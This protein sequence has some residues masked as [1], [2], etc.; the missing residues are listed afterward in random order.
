[1]ALPKADALVK[2]GSRPKCLVRA[3]GKVSVAKVTKYTSL[4][5]L[6]SGAGYGRLRGQSIATV[7]MTVTARV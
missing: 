2:N 3:S 6:P 5:S 7:R 4:L 1:M